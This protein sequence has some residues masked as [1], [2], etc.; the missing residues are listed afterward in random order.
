[1]QNKVVVEDAYDQNNIDLFISWYFNWDYFLT[2]CQSSQI[3]KN[4]K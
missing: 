3:K 1:M 4:N 2:S